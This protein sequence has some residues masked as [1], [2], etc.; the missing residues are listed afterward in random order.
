MF[1][2]GRLI[3]TLIFV[4]A[5]IGVLI[6]AYGRDR[7]IARIHFRHPWK[8]LLGLLAFFTLLFIIVK[9]RKFF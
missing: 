9:M 7:A 2:T 5:F 6:W 4:A 3:F 1:T 8:V